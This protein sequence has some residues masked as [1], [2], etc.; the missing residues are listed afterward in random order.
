MGRLRGRCRVDVPRRA[1]LDLLQDS[2]EWLKAF[3]S[4]HKACSSPDPKVPSK[5]YWA[6][7]HRHGCEEALAGKIVGMLIEANVPTGQS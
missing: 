3:A 7:F 6:L 5:L 2:E 4:V 1:L